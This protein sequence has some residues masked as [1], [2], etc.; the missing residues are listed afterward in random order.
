M[1]VP[2]SVDPKGD[3]CHGVAQLLTKETGFPVSVGIARK[4]V[5]NNI[6]EG[7]A[8]ATLDRMVLEYAKLP[9]LFEALVKVDPAGSFVL[10]QQQS[11]NDPNS[12]HRY[13]VCL[14]CVRNM[15]SVTKITL[16]S[17]DGTWSRSLF[18]T[19]IWAWC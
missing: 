10:V 6:P 13:Y 11:V 12:F 18:R 5:A 8:A 4:I 3:S 17:W 9:D 1:G 14:S 2:W 7:T 19:T 16:V 15:Q